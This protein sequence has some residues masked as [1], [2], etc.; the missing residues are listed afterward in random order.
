MAASS[1]RASSAL[2]GSSAVGIASLADIVYES[3]GARVVAVEQPATPVEGRFG[4]IY[5]VA[6]ALADGRVYADSFSHSALARADVRAIDCRLRLPPYPVPS[7]IAD[8]SPEYADTVSVRT[9]D[10]RELRS[11]QAIVAGGPDSPLSVEALLDKARACFAAG[12]VE[13]TSRRALGEALLYAPQ[14]RS[15]ALLVAATGHRRVT[16]GSPCSGASNGRG[17]CEPDVTSR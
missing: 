15:V 4:A 2:C 6:I 3:T 7:P 13:K 17:A 11:E 16:A 5:C 1:A 14:R 8:L 12:A 9:H 10:D